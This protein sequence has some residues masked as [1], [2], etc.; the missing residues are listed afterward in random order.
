MYN[1]SSNYNKKVNAKGIDSYTAIKPYFNQLK[2]QDSNLYL[3]NYRYDDI[4]IFGG[5]GLC[6]LNLNKYNLEYCYEDSYDSLSREYYNYKFSFNV[7]KENIDIYG[8][9]GTNIENVSSP[10]NYG[11]YRQHDK[12]D[13]HIIKEYTDRNNLIKVRNNNFINFTNLANPNSYLY[14]CLNK[15]QYGK[16][17]FEIEL[18][19]F[20]TLMNQRLIKTIKHDSIQPLLFNSYQRTL[21]YLISDSTY[22]VWLEQIPTDFNKYKNYQWLYFINFADTS[23][24]KVIKIDATDKI[25][26]RFANTIRFYPN[27]GE[28]TIMDVWQDSLGKIYSYQLV[29]DEHGNEKSYI[30]KIKIDGDIPYGGVYP[31]RL[32]DTISYYLVANSI[33]SDKY[34]SYDIVKVDPS[35]KGTYVASLF[36]ENDKDDMVYFAYQ[37]HM[38]DDDVIILNGVYGRELYLTESNTWLVGFKLQDLIKGSQTSSS[39]IVVEEDKTLIVYPNPSSGIFKIQSE[40]EIKAVTVIAPNGVE[41]IKN[42]QKSEELNISHLPNGIYLLVLYN[43]NGKVTRKMVVKQ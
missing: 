6:K 7:N 31:L 27:N 15:Y 40:S 26:L 33:K 41:I 16:I 12:N 20:D 19:Q 35:G 17:R 25:K 18:W 28:I 4:S 23:N 9:R 11:F 14:I 43:T 21:S 8:V 42:I 34:F 38:T 39:E 36:T 13:G 29:M 37:M 1:I 5:Y 24:I 3:I 22:M 30:E 10:L 2:V 32:T